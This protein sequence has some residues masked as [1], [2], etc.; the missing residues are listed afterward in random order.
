[1]TVVEG[2]GT[3]ISSHFLGCLVGPKAQSPSCTFHD[4][5]WAQPAENAGFVVLGQVQVGHHS[6][7]WIVELAF[8]SRARLAANLNLARQA[9]TLRAV[10]TKYVAAQVQ[11]ARRCSICLKISYSPARGDQGLV[12][13]LFSTLENVAFKSMFHGESRC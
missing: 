3:G 10:Y 2:I 5:V 8:T 13:E 12:T 4:Y 1:M 11:L 6:V 7:V 9:M